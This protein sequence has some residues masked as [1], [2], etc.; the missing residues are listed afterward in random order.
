MAGV[1]TGA[2][3]VFMPENRKH[4]MQTFLSFAVLDSAHETTMARHGS[5]LVSRNADSFLQLHQKIGKLRCARLSKRYGSVPR[6]LFCANVI[7]STE[8][9]GR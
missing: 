8:P 5:A 1:S 9:W 3:F 6:S 7:P 2:D 4:V